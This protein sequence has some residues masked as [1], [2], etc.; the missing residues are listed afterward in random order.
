MLT[1][2]SGKAYLAAQWNKSS[3]PEL[4]LKAARLEPGN[5]EYWAHAGLSRQWDTR[6]GAIDE[7]V[8]YLR[9]ATR[10]DPRSAELWMELA[11]ADQTLGD[12]DGAEAAYEKARVNY[13]A[14]GEVAWRYGN[15]LLYWGNI[16]DGFSQIRQAI[17]IDPLL[18]SS[19]I[20]TCWEFDPS[21]AAM[22]DQVLPARSEFY[23]SAI[24]FFVSKSLPGP[25]LAIWDRQH[26]L[27]MPLGIAEARGL[28]DALIVN[29]QIAEAQQVWSHV[30]PAPPDASNNGSLVMNGGFEH[31]IANAGFDWRELPLGG[32]RFDF[33]SAIAHSG[34]RSLRI[35]FDGKSNVDFEN[36]FQYVSVEPGMRYHFS[37]YLRTAQLST[38]HGMRF[39]ILD[40]RHSSQVQVATAE[41]QGTNPWTLIE[42]NVVAGPDTHLLKVTLQRKQSWKFDNKLSG[43]VWIDDVALTPVSTPFKETSR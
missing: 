41:V 27:G 43:T 31:D 28:V 23:A 1:F 10:V 12:L 9:R 6:P 5:A 8:N 4:W 33:D 15:F 14:S 22:L 26:E 38:D 39:E 19:A 20:A 40:I 18:T 25:A 32:A 16:S 13:P 42:T 11:D 2:L 36:V 29:D 37:A 24:D 17:S 30:Q 21:V 34:S 3:E 7:A 35:E